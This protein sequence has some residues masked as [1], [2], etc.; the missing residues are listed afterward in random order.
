MG[1]VMT[2]A[3]AT[4]GAQTTRKLNQKLDCMQIFLRYRSPVKNPNDDNV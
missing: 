2:N 1:F 3:K 4:V